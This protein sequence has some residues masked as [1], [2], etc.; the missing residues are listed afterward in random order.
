MWTSAKTSLLWLR[1]VQSTTVA[2]NN[3]AFI[4]LVSSDPSTVTRATENT[5]A[6]SIH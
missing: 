5:S 1:S 3:S 4:A 2:P 6:S